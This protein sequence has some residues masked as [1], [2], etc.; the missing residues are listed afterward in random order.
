MP[1]GAKKR[2]AAKKKQV[3]QSSSLS[4]GTDDVQ[5]FDDKKS[6]GGSPT[7]QDHH[8]SEHSFAE[9]DGKD[10]VFCGGQ[11]YAIATS[12][13]LFVYNDNIIN[14]STVPYASWT[15]TKMKIGGEICGINSRSMLGVHCFFFYLV[16][17]KTG[18]LLLVKRIFE[19]NCTT[20]S[21]CIFKLKYWSDT[22][23]GH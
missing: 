19:R 23:Y 15:W 18:D 1:S 12:G 9:G 13:A 11:F 14:G 16:E 5:H 17:S 4:Q 8:S 3:Q 7:S 22:I 10:I 20:K 6:D 2:K 21:F